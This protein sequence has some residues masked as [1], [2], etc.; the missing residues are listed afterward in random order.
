MSSTSRTAGNTAAVLGLTRRLA[1][2]DF[3]DAE[4]SALATERVDQLRALEEL[5]AAV[6]AAQVRVTAA[7][8]VSVQ[9]SSDEEHAA[10]VRV[11]SEGFEAWRARRD[12]ER[13]R[14]SVGAQVGLARRMSP[15]Q[16]ARQVAIATALVE[17]LPA[18]LAALRAGLISETRAAIIAR[19][20]SSLTRPDRR[21]LDA[22]LATDPDRLASWGDKELTGR[23]RAIAYRL[24]AQ[25]A[26]ERAAK[27]AQDRRVSLRPAPDAMSQLGALLPVPAGVAVITSL[28]QAAATARAQGDLRGRGQLMADTLVERVTGQATATAVPVEVQ[29][30]ISDQTLLEGR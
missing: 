10:R 23:V 8:T 3:A 7:L 24:D 11:G 6:A 13:S 25:A 4:R 16:G 9:R 1:A 15:H 21:L 14:S 22:E 29:V 27:A 19:E 20:S 18:T 17:D 5:K 28:E 2:L 26:V 30:V 12:A